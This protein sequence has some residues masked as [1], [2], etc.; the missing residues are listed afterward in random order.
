MDYA[1]A[2][3]GKIKWV[4]VDSK[5]G[6][7]LEKIERNIDNNTKMVF[8]ANPNNPT[9]TLLDKSSLS[10]FCERASDRTIVFCDEAYYDYIEE[11]DY[12]SMDYLVREGKNVIISRTFSK[13]YGMAGL[14]IG[15]LVLNPE[16]ADKL[17]GE[18]SPYGR[19]KIMAQT[20]VLAVAAASEALKDNDF[21]TFSLKKA[22]QEK[23][24]IYKLLDY[25]ELKYV[26]SSTNFVFFESKKHIDDLSKAM[27]DKG[28]RIGRPF[29]PFYDWC[30][31]STGTSQE[32]D[33]FIS[34]MLEVYS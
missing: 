16:L 32:V 31:I 25:L 29:P 30:R 3:G 19:A 20:N 1:E 4:P 33:K 26:K 11:P 5:K 10:N 21:Y 8:I 13:V 6:Y 14:R 28:V 15:Y 9:G 12:P 24:K 2:W 22:S 7:D 17:F 34:A 23:N 18:Y 27:L